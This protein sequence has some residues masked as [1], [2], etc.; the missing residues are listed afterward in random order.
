MR[1]EAFANKLRSHNMKEFWKDMNSLNNDRPKLAQR[2]DDVAGETDICNL[3][4]EKFPVLRNYVAN[5]QRS[6]QLE[7]LLKSA[8][9]GNLFTKEE[10][11]SLPFK[12]KSPD[13]DEVTCLPQRRCTLM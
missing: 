5:D 2:I 3:W 11:T 12:R 8:G 9:K 13:H 7:G 4:M 6:V 1:A 10:V